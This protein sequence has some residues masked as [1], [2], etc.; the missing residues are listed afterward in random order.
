LIG[1]ALSFPYA[2]RLVEPAHA[3]IKARKN[4]LPIAALPATRNQEL[5][6]IIKEAI[7]ECELSAD[8]LSVGFNN[9][10]PVNHIPYYLFNLGKVEGPQDGSV[11]FHKWGTKTTFRLS[12]QLDVER[13][14]VM[15]AMGLETLSFEEFEKL[16][17]NGRHYTPLPQNAGSIATNALQAPDRFVDEDVPMGLV[18]VA[19]FGDLVNVDTPV[20][21]VMIK[22]ADLVRERDFHKEGRTMEYMGLADMGVED[23]LEF[24]RRGTSR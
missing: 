24:V 16:A 3:G 12:H 19:E 4:R 10:N 18:P 14:R 5:L 2:T 23:I 22:I 6:G 7:P 11:D 21:D 9:P 20:T 17:Y 1:E 13:L 15:E 8:S